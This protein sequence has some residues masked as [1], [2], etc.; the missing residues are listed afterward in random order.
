[1][2]EGGKDEGGMRDRGMRDGGMDEWMD[3]RQ[4][5]LK[6][7]ATTKAKYSSTITNRYTRQT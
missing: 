3:G 2:D 4:F 5:T 7:F 1:M 6:K